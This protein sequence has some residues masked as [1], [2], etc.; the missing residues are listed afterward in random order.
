MAGDILIHL[1]LVTDTIQMLLTLGKGQLDG[2]ADHPICQ[3]SIYL[4]ES[5]FEQLPIPLQNMAA[6]GKSGTNRSDAI[7]LGN[8]IANSKICNSNDISYELKTLKS[9]VDV[10]R[11]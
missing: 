3:V 8:I 6:F 9:N 2:F 4:L 11:V 7:V 5:G 10:Y 1:T